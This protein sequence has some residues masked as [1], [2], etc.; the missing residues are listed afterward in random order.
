MMNRCDRCLFSLPASD[1]RL[2]ADTGHRR[3]TCKACEAKERSFRRGDLVERALCDTCGQEHPVSRLGGTTGLTCSSCITSV[4]EARVAR[5]QERQ[6]RLRERLQAASASALA[7]LP[8][9]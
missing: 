8:I 2:R 5:W 9:S 6:Q 3:A 1:F 4:D 7:G